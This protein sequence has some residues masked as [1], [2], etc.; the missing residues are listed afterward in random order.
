MPLSTFPLFILPLKVSRHLW[1][2]E[3]AT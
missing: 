3:W 2:F 1:Y